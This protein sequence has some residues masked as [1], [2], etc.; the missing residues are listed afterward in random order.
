MTFDQDLSVGHAFESLAAILLGYGWSGNPDKLGPDL[1]HPTLGA[2]ECKFDR[3]AHLTGNVFIET[4]YRGQDSGPFKYE[5]AKWMQGS[6]LGALLFSIPDLLH[7]MNFH[8]KDSRGGDGCL[9]EG[10]LVKWSDLERFAEKRFAI[11]PT[12]RRLFAP[13]GISTPFPHPHMGL[14]ASAPKQ[15]RFLIP[16]DSYPARCFQLIDLGTHFNEKYKKHERKVRIVWELPTV[17]H[18]FKEDAGDEP[19]AI[20]NDYSVS[21]A[22]KANLRADLEA[23]RG[24]PFTDQEVAGFDLRAIVGTACLVQVSHYEKNGETKHGLEMVSK[25]PS[26]MTC[27]PA[28]SPATVYDIEDDGFGEKFLALPNWMQEKIKKSKEYKD[29]QGVQDEPFGE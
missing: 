7:V 24:K 3:K 4:S 29:A 5:L 21:L 10:V 17:L 6:E 13:S 22:P 28:V 27:P 20:G 23:W 8:G 9:S 16:A 15:E 11:P 26:V 25:L 19:A 14:I 12:F 1:L 2:C 18:K